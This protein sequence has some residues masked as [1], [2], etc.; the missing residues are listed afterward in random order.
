MM[1]IMMNDGDSKKLYSLDDI[2]P[3]IDNDNKEPPKPKSKEELEREAQIRN[4][5]L[6]HQNALKWYQ[7]TNR[8][9]YRD[10]IKKENRDPEFFFGFI[11]IC[12]ECREVFYAKFH[13]YCRNCND[14][15]S[16]RKDDQA[17]NLFRKRMLRNGL[18]PETEIRPTKFNKYVEEHYETMKEY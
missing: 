7:K 8:P 5:E 17:E 3:T 6:F 18:N 11:K 16:T 9:R 14:I 1:T 12:K 15:S 2:F 10:K 4:M 13:R